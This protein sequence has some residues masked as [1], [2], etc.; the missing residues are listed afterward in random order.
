MEF[1]V[2]KGQASTRKYCSDA[3][4]IKSYNTKRY[5][6]EVPEI[7]PECGDRIEQEG[8]HGRYQR[9]CSDQCRIKYHACKAREE[10]QKEEQPMQERPNCGQVFPKGGLGAIALCRAGQSGIKSNVSRRRTHHKK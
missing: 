9:F 10:R 1:E 7:C 5:I 2:G 6:G 8:R 4:R 3:C